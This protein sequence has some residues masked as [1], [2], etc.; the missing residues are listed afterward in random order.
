MIKKNFIE[1][2]RNINI[3]G[4]G[5][6]YYIFYYYNYYC[7]LYRYIFNIDYFRGAPICNYLLRKPYKSA[8]QPPKVIYGNYDFD[9]SFIDYSL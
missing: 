9:S 7:I 3:Y 5:Y 1:F 6:F 2:Y 8:Q 4:S